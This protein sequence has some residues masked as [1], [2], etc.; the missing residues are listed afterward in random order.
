MYPRSIKWLTVFVVAVLLSPALAQESQELLSIQDCIQIAIQ[1]NPN[2]VQARNDAQV[3]KFNVLESYQGILPT[4]NSSVNTGSI[5]TGESEY[6]STEPVGIDSA[7]GTVLYEQRIRKTEQLRRNSSSAS[8]TLDQPLLDGGLWYNQIRQAKSQKTAADFYFDSQRNTVIL[9]VEQAF[10][11]L[12]K[13]EKLLEV[14]QL[15]VERSQA[16][17]NRAE[18]MFELGASAQIDVFRAKVSLGRDKI[19]FIN[20][21]NSVETARKNLNL[22]MGRDPLLPVKATGLL[23]IEES[24]PSLDEYLSKAIQEQPLVKKSEA[25]IKTSNLTIQMARGIMAPRLTGYVNYDRF[26]EDFDFLYK[27][28]DQNYQIRYGLNLS[29]NIF[30]GFSDYTAIQKAK[31]NRNSALEQFENYKRSL[32]SEIE[33][34]Y[35][36]YLSLLEIVRINHENLDA[37]KE[38]YRLAQE[39][40]LIGAGTSLDVREAQVNL[41][42]AEQIL[43]AA[44]YN[45]VITL[46]MLENSVG[47]IGA[48]Y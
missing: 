4:I 13:Q 24:L 22:A 39:R 16:Q 9:N 29:F 46:S 37:A 6:L 3:A 43:I 1:N 25:D 8:I 12:L 35:S 33:Q 20:Q 48:K 19:S 26:H 31:L 38:E 36:N 14:N 11:D 45:A 27:K 2:L 5:E 7:T 34:Y 41:T 40:F 18:K 42:D 10:Y 23:K 15:A 32:K 17:L 44:Q 21:Q 47:T 28:L 30:N